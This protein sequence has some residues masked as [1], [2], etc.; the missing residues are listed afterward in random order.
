MLLITGDELHR[1]LMDFAAEVIE[2]CA[3]AAE[4]QDRIGREWVHDS[5]WAAILKRAGDNVRALA[6]RP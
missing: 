2:R 3:V 4:A 1:E 5:L 6:P